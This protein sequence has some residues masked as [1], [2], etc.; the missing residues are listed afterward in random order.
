MI[1][2]E[3]SY[4]QINI[5]FESYIDWITQ[6]FPDFSI[7]DTPIKSF[8]A[9][10]LI[11]HQYAIFK[12]D[13]LKN[14]IIKI[15]EQFDIPDYYSDFLLFYSYRNLETPLFSFPS[16]HP[17]DNLSVI[18]SDIKHYIKYG[19]VPVFYD[20]HGTGNYCIDLHQ[21]DAIVFYKNNELPSKSLRKEKLASSFFS[22]LIFLR[23]YL[24][25]GGN[26][27]GLNDED[28]SEA[29]LELKNIDLL[30]NSTWS[31]WW[32]PRLIE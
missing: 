31:S 19:L 32:L 21:E 20:K 2:K 26:I 12:S 15:S 8:K 5:F 18:K 30:I 16:T 25:W 13:I 1:D 4:P 7:L 10:K 28:K 9:D 11:E 22:T 23:E 17:N 14:D 27:T 3:N 29:L 6:L 24:D